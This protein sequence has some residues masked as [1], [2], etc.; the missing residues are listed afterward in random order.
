MIRATRRLT[1]LVTLAACSRGGGDAGTSA[2]ARATTTGRA[3]TVP[4]TRIA[5]ERPGPAGEWSLPAGDYASSRYSA[6]DQITAANV[7][8]LHAAWAFSTGVLRG[9]EG[10]PLV[11]GNTMYVI[12]PYPNVAYALDLA[13][14]GQPLK[15]KVRPDNAQAA[16]G[17]ACC[18]VVNRGASYADGKIF[19]NLLDGHTVAVDVATG[20]LLW[21]T[22][23]ADVGRGET[24]TMAPLAVKGKVLVGS[25]GGEMGVRGWIAA[26]DAASGK[27]VWRAYNVGPDAD[28]KV[29]ARFKP[30]YAR[31]RG[32]NQG[33]SSWPGESWKQG[34]A[35][36]WGWLSYDPELNLVYHGTSNPGPWNGPQRPGD[37][38]WATSIIARD[39]DTGEMVWAFQ[40]T[41]HDLWDY[42]AVNENILVDLPVGG[43]TRKALVHF[44]RNGYAYTIDRT[45]GEV[46]LAKAYVE[47]NW[48]TGVD[49]ASGRPVLNPDKVT[50]AGKK[51]TNICPSLEGGKNQQPAAFSPRTGLF[52][53]PTN[54]LCMDFEAREVSYIAGTPYIGAS[55][56][57][58]AGP[59]GHR[60]EFMAWDATTGTKKWG[61]KEP[62]PV[63]GGALVTQGDVVFYGTLDG[64]LKA[65]DARDGRVLWQFKVGSGVVGNPMTYLG[66]DG[67]QYIAVYAG[68]GGDMG[69]LIAGDVAANLPYDVRER[70]TT[71]PDL[72]RW[73][74]WGGMLFVFSL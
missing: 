8:G 68:I 54:N 4:G 64:W 43:R 57:E 24:M 20:K 12:T 27:E 5:S 11:V 28:M 67:K 50:G 2:A 56:P 9:H 25:S 32:P 31:D 74:S 37:N 35:A 30:F 41:P 58:Y 15:W 72:S 23:M 44:D 52:Y 26:I 53:V 21:S 47:M 59:G 46:L 18:D 7:K 42:D 62:Y 61:I 17:V 55:A 40:P 16:V 65:A 49:L 39:A 29:G 3:T 51:V 1:V 63:W 19:Y 70:G 36:V 71:L 73:T 45:T 10:N 6:L 14:P 33:V 22:R 38:K 34:G 13:Q 48:S 66:P 60:G 69:L